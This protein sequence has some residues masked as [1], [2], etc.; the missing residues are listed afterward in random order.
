[1]V[2]KERK[3]VL[4][5][6]HAASVFMNTAATIDKV[7][8]FIEEGGRQ[9]VQFMAFPEAFVPGYPYWLNNFAPM[10]NLEINVHYTSVSIE[11]PGAEILR[12]QSACRASK[13]AVVLGV[14]ERMIGTR[15][16]FNTQVFIDRDGSILGKHRKLQPTYAEKMVWAHGGGATLR[17]FDSTVGR[18]GGLV[19]SEHVLC[20][21]K[22]ALIDQHEEIHAASW[23]AISSQRGL[24][25]FDGVVEGMARSHAYSAQ[26]FVVTSSSFVDQD[27][28]DWISKNVGHQERVQRGGGWSAITHPFSVHLAGPAAG[29]G[30]KLLVAE[31][32]FAALDRGKQLFDGAGHYSRPEVLKTHVNFSPLW[33]DESW[34]A[35]SLLDEQLLAGPDEADGHA[36]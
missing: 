31:V 28:L 15:T 18:L 36:M 33:A 9:G 25:T 30:E 4:A 8:G 26:A 14:S 20:G 11:I 7:V 21:A 2:L 29:V 12:V 23:P 10:F 5:A 16:C 19:C 13:V 22:Q 35:G 6:V 17:I 34:P 1:M 3:A 24:N 32:E 27:C